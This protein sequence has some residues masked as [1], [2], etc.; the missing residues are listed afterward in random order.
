M[1]KHAHCTE[2]SVECG[3]EEMMSLRLVTALNTVVI[4]IT[5]GR[6]VSWKKKGASSSICES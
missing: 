6:G 5:R 2:Q 3:D 1:C 4:T